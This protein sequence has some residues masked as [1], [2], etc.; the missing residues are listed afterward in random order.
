MELKEAVRLVRELHAERV[1]KSE[2]YTHYDKTIALEV[3]ADFAE[4]AIDVLPEQSL[5]LYQ[6]SL[7]S[8]DQVECDECHQPMTK[9]QYIANKG[10]CNACILAIN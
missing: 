7:D 4:F 1:E 8:A 9:Q 3:L 6:A 5:D 10:L 2:I